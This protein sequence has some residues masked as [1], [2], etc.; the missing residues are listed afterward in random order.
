MRFLVLALWLLAPVV[1]AQTPVLEYHRFAAVAIDSLTVSTKVLDEQLR[2]LAERHTVVQ[3]R[4]LVAHLRGE[5]PALPPGSVVLTVDDGHVSVYEEMYPRIRQRGFH[6]TLFVYPSAIS[7]APWALTWA[8]LRELA[9]SGLFDVQSHTYFHPDFQAQKKT[10]ASSAYETLVA[11]QLVRSRQLLASRLEKRIDLLAWPFGQQDAE[12]MR[13]A[14]LAGYAGAFT[15]GR[16]AV[17]SG[18]PVM[19]IP[20]IRM[21]DKHR[22]SA[23]TRLLH[24]ASP[25]TDRPRTP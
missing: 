21:T 19:A 12:L 18:D 8:Q 9:D 22:G 11:T 24:A 15:V 14:D 23:F 4:R 17:A 6:V 25:G 20:R 13:A 10:L 16:R 3:A 2:V 1:H 7:S 5:A